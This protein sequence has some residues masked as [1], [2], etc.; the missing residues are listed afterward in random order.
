MNKQVIC[1][2]LP[3]LTHTDSYL[4]IKVP[5]HWNVLTTCP[6]LPKLILNKYDSRTGVAG[7]E[8]CDKI[9]DMQTHTDTHTDRHTSTHTEVFIEFLRN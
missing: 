9:W 3:H 2:L 8:I 7:V 6:L 5:Y 1:F 4:S